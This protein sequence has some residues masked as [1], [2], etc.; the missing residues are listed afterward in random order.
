MGRA[1]HRPAL[2]VTVLLL[3]ASA[4]LRFYQMDAVPPGIA[5]D[6]AYNGLDIRQVL[7]GHL[8]LF[9]EANNGR[10]PLFIYF[11]A[12]LAAFGGFQPI[13]FTFSGAA[14]GMLTIAAACRLFRA[15]FSW[16]VA[17]ISAAL[18]SFSLWELTFSRIGLRVNSGAPFMLATL[19]CLWRVLRTGR[20]WYGLA[21][22]LILGLSLYTYL[23]ARFIPILVVLICL[24]EWRTARKRL[25]ELGLLV[26]VSMGVFLPEG[27]YFLRHQYAFVE[28]AEQVSIFNPHPDIV[29]T[30][31]TPRRSLVGTAR[32]FF[33]QGDENPQHNVPGTPIFAP[34]LAAFFAGGVVLAVGRAARQPKYAWPL[35]TMV[36]MSLASALSHTAPDEG[37][38]LAAAPAVFVFPALGLD[39]ARRALP[40]RRAGGVLVVV[41]VLAAGAQAGWRFF[42]QWAPTAETASTFAVTPARL[43]AV[44]NA[45]AP[46]KTYV[47]FAFD[48]TLPTFRLALNPRIQTSWFPAASAFVPLPDQPRDVVYVAAIGAGIAG[49]GPAAVP[50]MEPL[51]ATDDPFGKPAFQA[52]KLPAAAVARFLDGQQP[53]GVDMG[54]DFRLVSSEAVSPP[55]RLVGVMRI[56]LVA[57][58]ALEVRIQVRVP[59]EV[60]A[61]PGQQEEALE[62]FEALSARG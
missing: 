62:I 18:L 9:F 6:V 23:A 13:V 17:L 5:G 38:S 28:R 24:V 11:Q 50:G 45:Q 37:Q 43:A 48:D 33:L 60:L 44:V 49:L 1:A 31:S 59:R 10:E 40:W 39:W 54:G 57:R 15:L 12:V 56:R 26:V 22:G 30:P 52:F 35:L 61:V 25:P 42:A 32:M 36:L 29:G 8:P 55:G 47:A 51:G 4:F 19:Y 3:L 14:M 34:W 2:P 27:V 46:A 7:A 20:R 21:G 58:R 41:A 53:V 16:R